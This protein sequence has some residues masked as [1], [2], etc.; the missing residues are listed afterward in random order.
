MPS[1]LLAAGFALSRPLDIRRSGLYPECP[2]IIGER[3]RQNLNP[4]KGSMKT[5]T[6]QSKTI[7]A[8]ACI[9]FCQRLAAAQFQLIGNSATFF[10]EPSLI[11]N[12]DVE[13]GVA[14]NP[15]NT[16][17]GHLTGI[18]ADPF[19]G[20]LYGLTTFGSS[21]ANS[22]VRINPLTGA[23]TTVGA[24][25]LQHIY[26]G[27]LAFS[28]VT[29]QLF[30]LQDSP[31]APNGPIN[32]FRLDVNTGTATVIGTLP[33]S[34]FSDYSA[35]AFDSAGNLFVV[36]TAEGS[37]SSTLLTVNPNTGAILRSVTMNVAL[38]AA[39]GLTFD[40]TTGVAY[41]AGG[42]DVTNSFYR[43]NVGTGQASLIGQLHITEGLAG[44]A[45]IP[46][47]EPSA[48]VLLIVGGIVVCGGRP[49][50]RL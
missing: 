30:G 7:L 48:L 32:F 1:V 12:R 39:A 41:L 20:S 21:P 49:R 27:D 22:L 14:S 44:L 46:V 23:F 47:P 16:G 9:L 10:G 5:E 45:F 43:L 3:R 13:T 37:G 33:A 50:P 34:A 11:Y 19:S 26:E 6:I 15:R 40:P 36:N 38:G 25:G 18:A 24:T 8:I 2:R 42:D 35:M 29:G 17:I 4:G 31:N 28:P